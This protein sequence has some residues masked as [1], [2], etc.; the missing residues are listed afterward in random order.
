VPWKLDRFSAWSLR[1]DSALRAELKATLRDR[2]VAISLGEG[3]SIRPQEEARDKAADLDIMADLGAQRI[4]TVSMEP[5]RSRSLDEFGILAELTADRGMGLLLEFAPPHT[6]NTLEKS[7]AAIHHAGMDNA[8]LLIDA[9]HF[10]RTGGTI[11]QL[12]AVDPRMIGYAQLCDATIEPA[13]GDYYLEASFQRKAPG[14]GELPLGA[15]L[16]VLPTDIPL[17]IEVPM[18]NEMDA[19]ADPAVHI[20]RIVAAANRL[21][22]VKV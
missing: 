14:D 19:E 15:L 7:L 17:G 3:F 1:D 5:D 16:D 20:G 13:G 10:F 18:R 12:A 21:L 9:M 8:S 2:A 6:F 4:S 11:E 22:G